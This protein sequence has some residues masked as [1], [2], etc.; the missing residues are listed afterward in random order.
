MDFC[1]GGISIQGDGSTKSYPQP[2]NKAIELE[3]STEY[4][5]SD[6][7]SAGQTAKWAEDRCKYLINRPIFDC[8]KDNDHT[9][10]AKFGEKGSDDRKCFTKFC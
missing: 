3:I 1:R 9:Q 7:C 10:I 6:A 5:E 2:G 4:A 8:E